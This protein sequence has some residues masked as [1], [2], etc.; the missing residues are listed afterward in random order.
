MYQVLDQDTHNESNANT[1]ATQAA[2]GLFCKARLRG[3]WAKLR[4]VLERTPNALVDL[5]DLVKELKIHNRHYAGTKA[6]AVSNIQGTLGRVNDFGSE[7]APLHERTRDRW[8]SIAM[9]RY[10]GT[11]M[12]AVELIQVGEVYFVVDGHHRIS[13]AQTLG[14][15]AIDAVVTVWDIERPMPVMNKTSKDLGQVS[16]ATI[17]QYG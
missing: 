13:V 5:N 11:P 12:P 8:L 14:E 15:K 10:L 3:K 16:H 17:E 1:R 4:S 6:V 2:S 7:F 9:A